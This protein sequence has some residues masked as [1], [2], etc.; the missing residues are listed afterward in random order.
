MKR[1]RIPSKVV[2]LGESGVGKSSTIQTLK[3]YHET[4]MAMYDISF[5]SSTVGI[6]FVS[7][8]KNQISINV[9]DTAGSERFDSISKCFMRGANICILAFDSETTLHK[10]QLWYEKLTKVT[11]NCVVLLLR[12]KIDQD[13]PILQKNI[14]NIVNIVNAQKVVSVSCLTGV[15]ISELLSEIFQLV[16]EQEQLETGVVKIQDKSKLGCKICC[17]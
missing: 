16:I 2:L 6:D 13:R 11:D 14:D 7:L 8:Q 12:T 10:C 17:V 5:I 3:N 9:W 4:G 15:G 1:F